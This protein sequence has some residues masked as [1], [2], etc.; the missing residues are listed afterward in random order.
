MYTETCRESFVL[1][2]LVVLFFFCKLCE[3]M[4]FCPSRVTCI[5]NKVSKMNVFHCVQG[6]IKLYQHNLLFLG[7]IQFSFTNYHRFCTFQ[8]KLSHL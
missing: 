1:Y 5:S 4:G 3:A 6:K 2:S 8:P 7:K